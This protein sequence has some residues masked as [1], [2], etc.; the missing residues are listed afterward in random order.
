MPFIAHRAFDWRP[1]VIDDSWGL[2]SLAKGHAYSVCN[3][4]FCNDC[5]LLFLDI[6]FD[7]KEMS[8]IY[9][10]YRNEEYVALREHYE[11]GYRSRNELLN[12]GVTFLHEVEA[13]IRPHLRGKPAV[14][15]WGGD[16]GKN[17]PFKNENRQLDIYDISGKETI[18]GARRVSKEVLSKCTYDLVVCS[19][20]LEHVP[21]P[22]DVLNEIRDCM[23]KDT[24]LY[25]ELPHEDLMKQATTNLV[26]S[27]R[28][29][30]EHINFFSKS[31]LERLLSRV[32]F[33]V[34]NIRSIDVETPG[35]RS[36][37]FQAISKTA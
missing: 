4:L 9:S 34:L 15:D 18:L 2:K 25:I 21:Y 36:G 37:I 23:G 16:T 19:Q 3:S 8:R 17:T 11:P 12:K 7:D 14:L 29:W 32:G 6:R 28:H 10:G 31:A 20:V 27:K 22:A 24:L 35:K 5:Q 33:E 30:H 13:F 26:S 1:V